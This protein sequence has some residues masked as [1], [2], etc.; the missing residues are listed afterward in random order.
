[1][2]IIDQ[3]AEPP[4]EKCLSH[5]LLGKHA[6]RDAGLGDV[7][8]VGLQGRGHFDHGLVAKHRAGHALDGAL[9][10]PEPGRAF[11]VRKVLVIPFHPEGRGRKRVRVAVWRLWRGL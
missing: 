2:R 3:H 4:H 1:M 9:G 10:G 7:G 11:D 5:R 8:N 6:E